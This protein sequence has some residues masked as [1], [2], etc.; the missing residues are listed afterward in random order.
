MGI[1]SLFSIIS[2][3]FKMFTRPMFSALIII[4]APVLIILLAG[5]V[6]N[7]AGLSNIIVAVHSESYTE[8][9]EEL[10]SDFQNQGFTVNRYNSQEECIESVKLSKTQICA[11][12]PNDLS[13][14]GSTNEVIFYADQSRLN[15]AYN[16]MYDVETKVSAKASNLGKILA[17]DLI[18]AL[19]TVKKNLPEQNA[20]ISTSKADAGEINE[21]AKSN[22]FSSDID[23]IIL[24]LN[25]VKALINNS[26]TISLISDTIIDLQSVKTKVSNNLKNIENQS[27]EI[28][29]DLDSISSEIKTLLNSISNI[30]VLEAEK[31][32]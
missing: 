15:L 18:D 22:E 10:I 9:T 26:E 19:D 7:S 28:S 13:E 27:K 20:K 16:L 3:D 14:T 32:V 31:I 25:D 23:K 21:N 12:F 29:S 6:F 24:Q 5:L 17:Q 30:N 1:N 8:L 2:K 4:L 11:I